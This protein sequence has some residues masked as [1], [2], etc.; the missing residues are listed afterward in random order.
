MGELRPKVS[1]L[2]VT[3]NH[4]RFIA[5][6][7]QSVLDQE[8]DFP[9]EVIVGDDASTDGTADIVRQFEAR[10]PERIH[11]VLHP[12]N[13]GGGGS[14]NFLH[15]TALARGE[16]LAILEGDD[17]FTDPRKLQLQAEFLDRHPECAGCFHD[18]V[19]IDEDGR[20]VESRFPTKLRQPRVSQAEVI[21]GG[22]NAVTNTRMYR[23]RCVES[24]PPWYLAHTMD[25]G[26]EI[27]V[28][29][30]GDWGFLDR[31]MSAY[32]LHGGGTFSGALLQRRHEIIMAMAK[33]LLGESLFAE[34]HAALRERL[35]WMNREVADEYR[36]QGRLIAYVRHFL[37]SVAYTPDSAGRL[38]LLAAEFRKA[39]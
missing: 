19:V 1:V 10:E 16:Y 37:R 31:V 36:R 28:A 39:I 3:Y 34:H 9:F 24:Y 29:G 4:E 32:R 15:V 27:L 12:R 8:T 38:R 23:R 30:H 26:L 20:L 21:R 14:R 5:S 33:E 22:N 25:W 11:A 17:L 35:A 13:L 18:C 6:A 2:V 7:L